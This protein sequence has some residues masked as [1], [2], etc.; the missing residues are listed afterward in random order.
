M[1]FNQY[2]RRD[3]EFN[4]TNAIRYNDEIQETTYALDGPDS[5]IQETNIAYYSS[6]GK[7]VSDVNAGAVGDNADSKKSEGA[8][9]LQ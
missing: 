3:V 7:A 5:G 4:Y 8:A 9:M 6:L 1:D 2:H